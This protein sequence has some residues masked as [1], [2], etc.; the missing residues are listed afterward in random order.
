MKNGEEDVI[1]NAKYVTEF[2]NENAG[3]G[4]FLE[5]YLQNKTVGN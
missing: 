3:V 2:D 4:H 5:K 1:S